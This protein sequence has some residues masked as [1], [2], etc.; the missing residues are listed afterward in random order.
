MSSAAP[1]TS[2]RVVTLTSAATDWVVAMGA[3]ALLAGRSH[4]CDHPSVQ[5]R[6]SVT[7]PTGSGGYNVRFDRLRALR[8][9]LVVGFAAAA[10]LP[11]ADV[12]AASLDGPSGDAG[13]P[14]EVV[15]V[16]PA[17]FKDVLDAALR[18]GRRLG[19]MREV[20]EVVAAGEARLA[21]LQRHQGR[22]KRSPTQ[23]L[24]RLLWLQD[25]E[26]LRTAGGW[27]PD[28]A[29]HAGFRAVAAASGAPEARLAWDEVLA[30][31]PDALVLTAAGRRMPDARAAAAA[32]AERPGW[33]TLTAVRAGR[34][35]V[36]DGAR[37]A[38]RPGPGLYRAA[39]VLAGLLHPRGPVPTARPVEA[40]EGACV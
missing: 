28:V 13:R 4:A 1:T 5:A 33:S 31:D 12:L 2:P 38:R 35:A 10:D 8:P 36:L 26:P 21:A 40:D 39:E 32:L 6:P 22:T 14:P 37:F 20:M 3:D 11:G 27:V 25:D 29:A 34:V 23:A 15:V 7:A 19:R 16:T 24:P 18:L 30:A 17:T 9:D